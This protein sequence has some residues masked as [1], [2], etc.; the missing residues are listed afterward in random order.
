MPPSALFP[1]LV[2]SSWLNEE[3]DFKEDVL[4]SWL[5]ADAVIWLG[6]AG[7]GQAQHVGP[8]LCSEPGR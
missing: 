3:W 5:F 6:S 1:R 8:L 4:A 7:C 2:R